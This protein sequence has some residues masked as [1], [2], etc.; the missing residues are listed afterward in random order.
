[1]SMDFGTVE[2]QHLLIIQDAHSKWPEVKILPDTEAGTV[3]EVLRSLFASYGLPEEFLSDNGQPFASKEMS[4]F[5][6]RNGVVQTFSPTYHPQSA[7]AAENEVKNVKKAVRKQLLDKGT[8]NRTL[9][10]QVDAWLLAY[11]NTPHTVTGVS[12]SELFLGRRVRTPLSM[13]QPA[14]ILKMK[15]K[16]VQ[17][18][19]K[20]EQRAKI[21]V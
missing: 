21:S 8:A 15:M 16:A 1:M 7:G 2:K 20:A 13:L 5:F 14:N 19:K 6:T 17:E 3:I 9:Q 4:Q 18:K 10:H 11:R 12:P